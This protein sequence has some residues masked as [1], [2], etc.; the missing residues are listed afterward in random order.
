MMMDVLKGLNISRTSTMKVCNSAII[1][2]TYNIKVR[3]FWQLFSKP[4]RKDQVKVA[5]LAATQEY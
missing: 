4:S 2:F 1:D 5:K 3:T